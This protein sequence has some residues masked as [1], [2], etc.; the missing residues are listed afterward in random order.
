MIPWKSFDAEWPDEKAAIY[1]LK[2]DKEPL[3]CVRSGNGFYHSL[4]V[5]KGEE[6]DPLGTI[7]IP[8]GTVW[9][10]HHEY[11]PIQKP[12]ISLPPLISLLAERQRNIV[13]YIIRCAEEKIKLE[14]KTVVELQWI[15]RAQNEIQE[16]GLGEE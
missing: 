2:P 15:M 9:C 10:H 11:M 7:N 1:I 3:L 8:I 5:E 6:L 12:P 16:L 14:E 13:D 4:L